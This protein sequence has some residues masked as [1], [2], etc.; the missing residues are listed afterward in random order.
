MPY[1]GVN[2]H[3]IPFLPYIEKASPTKIDG[4]WRIPNRLTRPIDINVIKTWLASCDNNHGKT[5]RQESST[6]APDQLPTWLVDV[7]RQCIVPFFLGTPYVA[8]SYV[9]GH[10]TDF[11]SLTTDTLPKLISEGALAH[12][13]TLPRTIH[14]ML[15]LSIDLGISH[16]WIDRLCIVQDDAQQKHTQLKAMGS[17]YAQAYVTI[18]AAQSHDA[19]GPLSSR[20]LR[21]VAPSKWRSAAQSIISVTKA[22]S[23]LTKQQ[24]VSTAISPSPTRAKHWSPS[25]P[26]SPVAKGVDDTDHDSEAE[27]GS[28][29]R[30][31]KTDKDVLNIMSVDLLRTVW[32]SRGWTFQEFLFSRRKIV[33]H[34]N[35]VNW[36]CRCAA[37]HERQKTF[38]VDTKWYV[39]LDSDDCQ[40]DTNLGVDIDTWPN[41]HRYARLASLFTPRYLTYPEDSLDAFAGASTAFA[42]VYAGGLVTGL[43]AMVFDAALIWLPY[44]PLQ[45]RKPAFMSEEEAV[46][47]SWSWVS[48]R[49]NVQSESWG[50]GWDYM[51][52][53]THQDGDEQ[54][55]TI[56]TVEW[57]HSSTLH[58][59]KIPIN[60]LMDEWRERYFTNR[61]TCAEPL[62]DG[63]TK[64]AATGKEKPYFSHGTN[65]PTPQVLFN[66]P[67]PIGIDVDGRAY[68]SRYLHTVTRHATFRPFPKPRSARGSGCAVL[69]LQD[70]QNGGKLAGSLRLNALEQ[71]VRES[72]L[73]GSPLHLIELSRG[74]ASFDS[75]GVGDNEIIN[76]GGSRGKWENRLTHKHRLAD[77]FDE[78]TLPG[79]T[80]VHVEREGSTCCYEFYNVMWVEWRAVEEDPGVAAPESISAASGPRSSLNIASRLAV[81]RVERSV[82]ERATD[83]KQKIA[84]VLG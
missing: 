66:Y 49:G 76:E 82:W 32:F 56:S 23:R 75:N 84:V 18:I 5:C 36:E 48:W 55:S 34:N 61:D 11:A 17:I 70:P 60:V 31:P 16:V 46:L 7:H 42:K 62:P 12:A 39:S 38:T 26:N 2:S 83:G 8:L 64:H 4:E 57:S 30:K 68:R 47:P 33:F 20:P 80:D 35:T 45:R 3:L 53:S 13:N 44:H 81:G 79:W 28:P 22:V 10:Q 58:S 69:A 72:F 6:V 59:P 15:T 67:I 52:E 43:P 37:A 63:W 24:A 40:K 73:A 25:N 50:S 14:D 54:W 27:D 41:F 77:V 65:M 1:H 51:K 78:M 71:D 74:Y 29:W 9:W 19:S 21:T